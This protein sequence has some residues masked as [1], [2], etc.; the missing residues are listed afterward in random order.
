MFKVT[1]VLYEFLWE[2]CC[3]FKFRVVFGFFLGMES[4]WVRVFNLKVFKVRFFILFF[5]EI[6]GIVIEKL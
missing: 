1:K 2:V 6:I 3:R 5:K 4:Y